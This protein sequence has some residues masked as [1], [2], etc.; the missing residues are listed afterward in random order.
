MVPALP[1]AEQ[2]AEENFLTI[3]KKSTAFL[4]GSPC[5]DGDFHG[6]GGGGVGRFPAKQT[7]LSPLLLETEVV[8][9][10]EM[11]FTCL[12]GSMKCIG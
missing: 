8:A 5:A 3:C 9:G 2:Q 7:C 4:Q 6:I 11:I 12:K 10:C 1:E